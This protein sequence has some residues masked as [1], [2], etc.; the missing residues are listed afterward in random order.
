M[1][2]AC[3]VCGSRDGIVPQDRILNVYG[4]KKCDH[5]FTSVTDGRH[6]QYT[7]DYFTTHANWFLYPNYWL[8]DFIYGQ[9][10]K[11]RPDG[12]TKLLD[13]GCGTG[14]LLKFL[15]EKDPGLELYGIDLHPNT[16]KGITFME[17]DVLKVKPDIKF[18][19]VTSLASIEHVDD[20][21]LFVE[22][23]KDLLSP[24]GIFVVNTVNT[25]GAFYTTAKVLNKLGIKGP[26]HSLHELAHLHHFTNGSL[27]RLLEEHGFEII[28][29]K[30]HNYP[31]RAISLPRCGIMRQAVYIFGSAVLFA[32]PSRFGILQTVI[33]RKKR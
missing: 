14:N 31:L 18:D 29:Q 26:Y 32:L 21:A 23:L 27:K 28:L 9:V 16:H 11:A 20:A 8:Y 33:C 6:T 2:I 22:R 4:C 30:N 7:E 3:P 17:G 24:G 5:S 1:D 15:L 12:K 25:R 19:V 13:A 10:K